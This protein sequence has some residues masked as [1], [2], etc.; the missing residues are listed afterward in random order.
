MATNPNPSLLPEIGPDGLPRENSVI[1]YTEKVIE[2]EQLQLRKYIQENYSK[3]RDV[4]RELENLTMEMKLTSGPKKAVGLMIFL[5][6]TS[7]LEHMR[8]KIENS[9]EKIHVAKVKEE[10]ARKGGKCPWRGCL[11]D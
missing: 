4:E 5:P 3:I 8:K 1:S 6:Y 9:T 2:E 10:E 7:A 11:S